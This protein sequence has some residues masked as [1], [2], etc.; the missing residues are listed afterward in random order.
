MPID[1]METAAN[2]EMVQGFRDGY[3]LDCPEPSDNRSHSYKHG[4]KAG[5]NDRLP[6]EERP[7]AGLSV[8]E[9]KLMADM[10]M[11]KDLS[12]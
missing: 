3:D 7:F 6:W 4:F 1:P 11:A 8:A 12:H 10:A 9:I 2:D 5:R